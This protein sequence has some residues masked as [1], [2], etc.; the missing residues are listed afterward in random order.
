[1]SSNEMMSRRSRFSDK[2]YENSSV[3]NKSVK[4]ELNSLSV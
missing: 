3:Y 1:M 2:E 4:S